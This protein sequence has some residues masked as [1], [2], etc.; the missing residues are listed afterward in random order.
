MLDSVF[1]LLIKDDS[2][3]EILK[4]T[5]AK[6]GESSIIKVVSFFDDLNLVRLVINLTIVS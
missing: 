2:S 1:K 3:R 6:K 5:N 4:E